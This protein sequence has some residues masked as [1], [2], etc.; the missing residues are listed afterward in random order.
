MG[1]LLVR[2]LGLGLLIPAIALLARDLALRSDTGLFQPVAL[3]QYWQGWWPASFE[4]V[5]GLVQ[6]H[7]SAT[8]WDRLLAPALH[9]P[10]FLL[11][12]SAGLLLIVARQLLR[13]RYRPSR[14]RRGVRRGTAA[15]ATP[16]A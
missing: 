8:L 7:L 4:R 16:R 3:G 13:L 6:Q 10:A 12:G 5:Q 14:R 15:R 2:L 1:R 9:L 11:F